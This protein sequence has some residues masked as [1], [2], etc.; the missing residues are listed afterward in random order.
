MP[1]ERRSASWRNISSRRGKNADGVHAKSFRRLSVYVYM[2]EFHPKSAM[3]Q[4]TFNWNIIAV[5]NYADSDRI[6]VERDYPSFP[7]KL[8]KLMQGNFSRGLLIKFWYFFSPSFPSF[9]LLHLPVASGVFF[10]DFINVFREIYC[11]LAARLTNKSRV[12][13]RLKKR[14]RRNWQFISRTNNIIKRLYRKQRKN[15]IRDVVL[16]LPYVWVDLKG[17]CGA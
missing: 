13:I 14:R 7:E 17:G 5:V 1:R 15:A 11:R 10:L 12:K 6:P 2:C 4:K 8:Q 16:I 3:G 9:K